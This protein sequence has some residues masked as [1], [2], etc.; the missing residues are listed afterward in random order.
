MN[1]NDYKIIKL[2]NNQTKVSIKINDKELYYVFNSDLNNYVTDSYDTFLIGILIYA[3]YYNL[4]INIDGSIS[5]KL[6][7]NLT[8]ELIPIIN[9]CYDKL[10]I[11]QIKPKNLVS[12]YY[13]SKETGFGL[14]CGID[15]LC[16]L[17]DVYF[18]QPIDSLKATYACNFH[19]G[20]SDNIEQYRLRLLHVTNFLNNTK[21]KLLSI[22][23]N[24]SDY[25]IPYFDHEKIHAFKTIS[26][27][28]LFQKLFKRFYIASGL[29]Y[30]ETRIMKN[31]VSFG[32]IEGVIIPLLST[33]SLEICLHGN[34]YSRVEKTNIISKNSLYDNYIDV[35]IKT[36]KNSKYLNC[37]S[38]FKCIRTLITLEHFTDIKRY[39]NIFNLTNYYKNK[40]NYIKKLNPKLLALDA[41]LVKLIKNKKI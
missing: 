25:V 39:S 2:E 30:N 37:G 7:N 32:W 22:E 35:C 41:Q 26:F 38:C 12:N 6:Y 21:L 3:M 29:T 11:I 40:N 19:S 1:L 33:E 13:D 17:E 10:N 20:G 31:P 18:K 4:D 16:T 34:K 8:R 9:H 23:S 36:D 28:Y 27:V 15:S 5:E 24:I 14:S